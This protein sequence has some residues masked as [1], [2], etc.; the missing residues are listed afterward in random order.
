MTIDKDERESLHLMLDYLLNTRDKLEKIDP[1]T[2]DKGGQFYWLYTLPRHEFF[3]NASNFLRKLL[4]PKL[5]SAELA[6]LF[7]LQ[8]QEDTRNTDVPAVIANSLR[9]F[10]PLF[11]ERAKHEGETFGDEKIEKIIEDLMGIYWG[12]EPRFFATAKKQQGSHKRPYRQARLRLAALN[13]DKYLAAAGLPV[14]ERHAIISEAFRA[15]WDTIRKWAKPIEELFG[16]IPHAPYFPE[17]A[18]AEYAE[19]P[20]GVREAIQRDGDAYWL[21]KNTASSGKGS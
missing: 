13:W 20:S 11:M 7:D 12:D 15:D 6:L 18:K 5:H 14:F 8:L 9:S 17:Q 21:E 4:G 10:L 19:N 3:N 2:L 1:D 16:L